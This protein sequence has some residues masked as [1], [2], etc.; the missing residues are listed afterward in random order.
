MNWKFAAVF[1]L[2]GLTA[3]AH[4]D[5][6]AS[7]SGSASSASSPSSPSGGS[8]APDS[9]SYGSGSAYSGG[10]YGGSA[11]GGAA[12]NCDAQPVQNLIGKTLTNETTEQARTG[13]NSAKVRVLKPGQV[14][15][16]EYDPTRINLITDKNN[17]LT[18]L[19]CG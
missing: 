7:T 16:M 14:M 5:N 13:S 9:G 18:A 15:T 11:T 8:A 17:A 4:N 1:L 6:I 10:S 2:V 3:C 12:A 19:R